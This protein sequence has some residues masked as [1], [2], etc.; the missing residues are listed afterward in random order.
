VRCLTLPGAGWTPDQGDSNPRNKGLGANA[1]EAVARMQKLLQLVDRTLPDL[2]A[3]ILSGVTQINA[4]LCG[5]YSKAPW[6]PQNCPTSM[7]ADIASYNQRMAAIVKGSR[8]VFFHDPNCNRTDHEACTGAEPSTWADGDYFTW[9]IHF[10][11][12]G[13]AKMAARWQQAIHL[14]LRTP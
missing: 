9:G 8:K 4:T 12:S 1:T 14:H 3:V 13:Y 7:P 10:S 11:Q 5:Q 2:A 6:H